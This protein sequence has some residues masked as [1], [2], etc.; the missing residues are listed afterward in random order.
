MRILHKFKFIF[1]ISAPFIHS[2]AE[3]PTPIQPIDK[4]IVGKW[5]G[6]LHVDKENTP[7]AKVNLILDAQRHFTLERVEN[8]NRA[9]G[10][11]ELDQKKKK[12]S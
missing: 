9:N 6:V 3:N 1:I 8:G 4:A 11:F 7:K 10:A 12:L 5:Q 2:C